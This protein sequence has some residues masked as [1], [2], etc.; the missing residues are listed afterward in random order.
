M[1]WL[2]SYTTDVPTDLRVIANQRTVESIECEVEKKTEPPHKDEILKALC[3]QVS[4]L[5]RYS[6]GDM[7]PMQNSDNTIKQC[8][9]YFNG[10]RSS[11][12]RIKESPQVISM[13]RQRDRMFRKTGFFIKKRALKERSCFTRES[14]ASEHKI[15][16]CTR[17]LIHNRVQGR[18]GVMTECEKTVNQYENDSY[19][20]GSEAE[21]DKGDNLDSDSHDDKN[22]DGG[23]AWVVL[24]GSTVLFCVFGST[25]KGFGVFFNG[26]IDEFGASSSITAV[27]PGV[28]QG[29]Y[30]LF[31]LPVLTIG[32]RYFT[33]R[34]FCI[35][36]GLLAS[37]AFISCSFIET[38]HILIIT[39]GVMIGAAFSLCHG[40]LLY[41]ISLY[42]VKRRNLAQAIVVAGFSFGGFVFPPVY[43]Y[44][45]KEYG[46]RGGTLITGG[47]QLN[48]VAI[49]L[50]LRPKRLKA[51]EDVEILMEDQTNDDIKKANSLY[52]LPTKDSTDKTSHQ[53]L[54]G[55][56]DR[57]RS[58]S[59]SLTYPMIDNVNGLKINSFSSQHLGVTEHS[60][61]FNKFLNQIS[62]SNIT[63][64]LGES[65]VV[66]MSLSELRVDT[67][68]SCD[69]VE[70]NVTLNCSNRLKF[71]VDCTVFHH[72]FMCVFLFVYCF[73]SI[74]S[75]YVIIFIAPFAKDNGVSPERVASLVSI[76]NACDFTGRLVNGLI[77]D[78][79]ILKNHQSILITLSITTV[80]LALSPLYTEYWHFVLLAVI[81][82][83]CAGGIFAMT[84]SVVADFLGIDNFRSAMG[85]LV[86]GQG[87][88][89][90]CSA[91]FIGYLRD[92]T[93]TYI[94]SFLFMAGCEFIAV[95]VFTCGLLVKQKSLR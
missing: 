58:Y 89:L 73:G 24:A 93:G 63:R 55:N 92:V 65:G 30:S 15:G 12:E 8:L 76:V 57:E 21:T 34:Q 3:N 78:R 95:V 90:G 54:L 38:V 81:A 11:S 14:K 27:I 4:A 26:F 1:R 23:W 45:I 22:V 88:T 71:F 16:V 53:L 25:M 83:F 86:L 85:I 60:G 70:S 64:V 79:K 47:I 74:G 69:S 31:T 67:F 6:K 10:K 28:L 84:P 52:Q 61:S 75:A 18:K 51:Q 91:P 46:L 43:T 37:A 72:W 9:I 2:P 40:P 42:F 50:L 44:L 5:P 56:N 36:T 19:T 7:K 17:V 68:K 77:T 49:A 35:V 39:N 33:T 66:S 32:L 48:V 29:T 41:L 94:T 62:N 13:L 82:G 87:V 80:C 59:E 20:E